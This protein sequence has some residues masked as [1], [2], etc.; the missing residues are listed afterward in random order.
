MEIPYKLYGGATRP[1]A[2]NFNDAFGQ[3][4]L[5]LYTAA[6]PEVQQELGLT[7]GYRSPE[8]QAKL[9]AASDQSGRTVA[10]PG[11]SKHQ[12]GTAADLYGFGLKGGGDVSEATKQWVQANAGQHGLYFPMDYEP[13]HIQL[14]NG[15]AAPP[16]VAGG[17]APTMADAVD[18]RA[19]AMAQLANNPWKSITDAAPK[20]GG[21]VG[22]GSA[23]GGLST[24]PQAD[25]GIP[26]LETASATL[27]P[28]ALAAQAPATA[29]AQVLG[30][31]GQLFKVKPFGMAAGQAAPM[32]R[33]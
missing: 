2:L 16:P 3:A 24:V 11:K 19:A 22:E 7:S 27:T 26:A 29:P 14:A 18:P 15:A 20:R 17:V 5:S 13:W 23:G 1:D 31:L 30:Q 12:H 21:L 25:P 10:A 32:R 9:F 6:P 33:A 28:D 8:V 4:L